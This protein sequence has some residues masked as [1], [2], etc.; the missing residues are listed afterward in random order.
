MKP[1]I[2]LNE[3]I[4]LIDDCNWADWSCEYSLDGEKT[5]FDGNVQSD[6]ELIAYETLRDEAGNPVEFSID[7]VSQV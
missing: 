6:G 3:Q 5:W 1:K 7:T 2:H 4:D